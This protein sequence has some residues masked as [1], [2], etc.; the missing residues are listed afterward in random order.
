MIF[1]F[2]LL[3][4]ANCGVVS[5]LWK[6]GFSQ[7]TPLETVGQ[8]YRRNVDRSSPRS[9][10]SNPRSQSVARE[11]NRYTTGP[12][13]DFSFYYS[14]YHTIKKLC[15]YLSFPLDWHLLEDSVLLCYCCDLTLSSKI[16]IFKTGCLLCEWRILST[17]FH[18]V[19][20][21]FSSHSI[22]FSFTA[23]LPFLFPLHIT[24]FHFDDFDTMWVCVCLIRKHIY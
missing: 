22:G 19:F 17:I 15:S 11:L 24:T 18:S 12:T 10:T 13:P 3:L 9:P 7:A 21:Y 23:L 5:Q 1:Y 8:E 6:L 14:I 20:P 16:M 4:L 2:L